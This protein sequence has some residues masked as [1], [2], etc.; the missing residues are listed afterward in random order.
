MGLN[1]AEAFGHS[2]TRWLSHQTI[3]YYSFLAFPD[4]LDCGGRDIMLPQLT[5]NL[6]PSGLSNPKLGHFSRPTLG[7]G[8]SLK[9]TPHSPQNFWPSRFM[10]PQLGHLV[11]IL[12][13]PRDSSYC[14][15]LGLPFRCLSICSLI[16]RFLLLGSLSW[17]IAP[18]P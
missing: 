6:L 13:I 2:S 11:A 18:P 1:G 5:Q 9:L 17:L 10:A 3:L 7:R 8:R 14:F 12:P 4:A 16:L 15:L